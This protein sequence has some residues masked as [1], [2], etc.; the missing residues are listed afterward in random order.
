[1]A[2]TP[3]TFAIADSDQSI[4]VTIPGPCKVV[5]Y[6]QSEDQADHTNLAF[7][8]SAMTEIGTPFKPQ[9]TTSMARFFIDT[10]LSAGTYNVTYDTTSANAETLWPVVLTGRAA[11]APEASDTDTSNGTTTMGP[12]LPASAGADVLLWAHNGSTT[13]TVTLSGSF[14]PTDVD[15][16]DTSIG[17]RS[18]SAYLEDVAGGTITATLTYSDTAN[19]KGAILD[20]FAEAGGGGGTTTLE[21]DPGAFDLTGTDASLEYNRLISAE[22]GTFTLTGADVTLAYVS[23]GDITGTVTLGGSPV[24]GATVRLMNVTDDTYEADTTTDASGNY[25]FSGLALSKTY[26]ATVEWEDGGTQYNARSQPFLRPE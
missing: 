1:M 24:E 21:A 8:G 23:E 16:E 19:R 11:G 25:T 22:G 17:Y 3:V 15:Q 7:N 10:E 20:S 4:P 18:T 2:I 12:S 13:P 26:H 9:S 14:S 6:I 5:V